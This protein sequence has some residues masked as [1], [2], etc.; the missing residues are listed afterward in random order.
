MKIYFGLVIFSS[1]F[2]LTGCF[3]VPG[4]DRVITVDSYVNRSLDIQPL[5]KPINNIAYIPADQSLRSKLHYI[6]QCMINY[7]WGRGWNNFTNF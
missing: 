5:S 2:F 7:S 1:L 4:T 3:T 6:N